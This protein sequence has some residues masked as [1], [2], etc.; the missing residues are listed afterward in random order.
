MTHL[1]ESRRR[2]EV[3][4]R[5][6]SGGSITWPPAPS[7]A[8][9]LER[10]RALDQA[11]IALLYKRYLPVVYRYILARVADVPQ[12]E[13]ITSDTFFAMIESI[14]TTRAQDELGFMAWLLGI[15]RNKV[16]LHFRR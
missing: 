4:G 2:S 16:S 11:S 6:P 9:I 12:A 15:A 7:F 10:A 3:T 8:V 13:D 5:R 14:K 1:E